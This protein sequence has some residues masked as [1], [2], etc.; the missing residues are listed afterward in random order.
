MRVCIVEMQKGAQDKPICNFDLSIVFGFQGEKER[1]QTSGIGIF[2]E[3]IRLYVCLC[4]FD[5]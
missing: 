2:G 4:V 5:L 3:F 1:E